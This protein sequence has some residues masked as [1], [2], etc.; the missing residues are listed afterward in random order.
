MSTDNANIVDVGMILNTA[1]ASNTTSDLDKAEFIL[2]E[3]LNFSGAKKVSI[4]VKRFTYTNWFTNIWAS[5]AVHVGYLNTLYYSDDT[6]TGTKYS[7]TIPQGSYTVYSLSIVIAELLR[8]NGHDNIFTLG[9][10][11]YNNKIYWV[12]NEAGWYIYIHNV[13]PYL[14]LGYDAGDNYVPA[15]KI[16]S[17]GEHII[18]PN[19]AHFNAVQAIEL[20]SNLSW[21]LIDSTQKSSLLCEIIPTVTVGSIH[22]FEPYNLTW[23]DSIAI[24]SGVSSVNLWLQD[25]NGT[26]LAMT[27]DWSVEI[28]IRAFF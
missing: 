12:F 13:S 25:Q 19:I 2:A 9:A 4:A 3:Q 1:T 27:E 7:I 18:A 23:T 20:R 10:A 8:H 5:G 14:L 22:S 6:G 15:D 28:L 17:I 21:G 26:A 24:K 11:T 16:S